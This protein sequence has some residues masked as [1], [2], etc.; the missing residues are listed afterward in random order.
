M[1]LPTTRRKLL[2]HVT[3]SLSTPALTLPDPPLTSGREMILVAATVV[4]PALAF[5][6]VRRIV[7]ATNNPLQFS[8]ARLWITL[9]CEVAIL[10]LW[11]PP[12]RR[13]GWTL[14][15]LSRRCEVWDIPR[16]IALVFGAYVAAVVVSIVASAWSPSLAGH[17]RAAR[18]TGTVSWL[19]VLGASTLNPVFEE[20]LYLGY[21]ANALRRWSWPVALGASVALRVVLHLYQGPLAF[22]YILPLGV[23]FST[24]YLRTGRMWPV[25]V[26]HVVMDVL[27]LAGIAHGLV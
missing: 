16:G 17:I 20:S 27:P 2:A 9:A 6:A 7:A 1:N 24:Y 19:A 21:L 3:A 11:I 13:R 15:R 14:Q 18:T 8:D 10:C 23:L 22:V 25:V 12:L 26:A 5:Q 4:L